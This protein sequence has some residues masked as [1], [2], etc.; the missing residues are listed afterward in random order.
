MG[1]T[2]PGDRG[3]HEENG[4]A[5]VHDMERHIHLE[6]K[7]TAK[8]GPEHVTKRGK[9]SIRAD[10]VNA[11]DLLRSRRKATEEIVGDH[12]EAEALHTHADN[13]VT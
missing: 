10:K 12:F 9:R 6:T 5:G 3:I 1:G 7:R 11:S 2:H 13:R 4:A 8:V